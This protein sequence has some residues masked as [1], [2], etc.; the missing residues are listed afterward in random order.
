MSRKISRYH[1]GPPGRR[2]LNQRAYGSK[3]KN[4]IVPFA[5][6]IATRSTFFEK[7]LSSTLVQNRQMIVEEETV[8]M[9]YVSLINDTPDLGQDK[10]FTAI[11]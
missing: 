11:S 1:Y 3:Q 6:S 5:P 9:T 10:V 8:G 7:L 2:D 4:W